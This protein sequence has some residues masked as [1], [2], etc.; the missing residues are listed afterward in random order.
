MSI[1]GKRIEL[2]LACTLGE[3][4]LQSR[5]LA[6]VETVTAKDEVDAA[7]KAVAKEF[8]DKLTGL[9]ERQRLLSRVI[10]SGIE[11]RMVACLVK[12]HVPAEATK[13]IIRLDTGDVV[14]EEAMTE[15]ECQLHMFASQ[16]EFERFMGS[17]QTPEP[18]DA[19]PEAGSTE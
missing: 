1:L 14:R 11:H 9:D 2:E 17:Q 15:S 5:S 6:L 18:G 8:R 16:G 3:D 7:R 10:R 19:E 12:F 13:R 4:E